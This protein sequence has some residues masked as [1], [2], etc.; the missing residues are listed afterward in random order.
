MKR[1]A[2]VA[3]AALLTWSAH[4]DEVMYPSKPGEC[5]LIKNMKVYWK[6]FRF[7]LVGEG[8]E[9]LELSSRGPTMN[10]MVIWQNRETE[11]VASLVRLA[12][13]P[14]AWSALSP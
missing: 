9:P 7:S 5:Y 4:A 6:E 12:D 8:W 11:T 3:A 2:L 10:A 14:T 1:F 13:C